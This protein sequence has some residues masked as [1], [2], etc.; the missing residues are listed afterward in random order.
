MGN[1]QSQLSG[2]GRG[3]LP[4]GFQVLRNTNQKLAIEP[5]FDFVVGINGRQI[6]DGNPML[7]QQEVRNCV[8]GAVTLGVWSAKGQRL[9]DILIPLPRNSPTQSLGLSLQWSPLLLTTNIWHVLEVSPHSPTD[10]AG[11]LPGSDYILGSPD[12]GGVQGENGMA[13]L[14]EHYLDRPLRLWVYN[15]EVDVVRELTITPRRG[16]GGEGAMGC[17]LGFGALHRLPVEGLVGPGGT[18]FD[19]GVQAG[20]EGVGVGGYATTT[21]Y[22]PTPTY[23]PSQYGPPPP[24]AVPPQPGPAHPTGTNTPPPPTSPQIPTHGATHKPHKPRRHL[25][26]VNMDEYMRESEQ[27]SLELDRPGSGF[28]SRQGTP[29]PPPPRASVP[30][31]PRRGASVS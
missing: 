18:L 27:Q 8:G 30:P 11:F 5:W 3:E 28:G 25:P 15:S 24:R 17:V 26:Q 14:V 10:L 12:E 2:G 13:D 1:E 31:P 9:R 29:L 16:W 6:D 22:V 23:T 4:W 20:E 21:G 7:F 19:I